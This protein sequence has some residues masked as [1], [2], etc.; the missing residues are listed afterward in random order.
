MKKSARIIS[1]LLLLSLI[2]SIVAVAVSAADLNTEAPIS[3]EEI[4]QE[5]L[6]M[7]V[8]SNNASENGEKIALLTNKEGKACGAPYSADGVVMVPL[9]PIVN[10][11]DTQYTMTG[12]DTYNLIFSGRTVSLTEGEILTSGDIIPLL[13][14]PVVKAEGGLSIMYIALNDV[15][16]IFDGYFVTYDEAGLIYVSR[17]DEFVNRN[18]NEELMQSVAKTFIYTD[19]DFRQIV[20]ENGKSIISYTALG[21][22]QS[23]AYDYK[24]YTASVVDNYKDTAELTELYSMLSEGTNN[25]NHPYINTSQAKFDELNLTYL[26]TEGTEYYDEEL[27]WYIE[28]QIAYADKYLA[29]WANLDENKNYVSLKEGQ[30][31]YDSEGK[32]NEGFS[33]NQNTQGWNTN[34]TTGT[35]HSVAEMPYTETG[36][37]NTPGYGYDPAG[38]RLNVL[39]N[40]ETA[41]VGAL[42]PVALAYQIT[43]DGKYLAFA[44]DWMTALCSWEH[45]GPGHYLNCANTARPLA[46]AYDWLYND[47]VRVYGQEAVEALAE[48]IYE[49]AVYEAMIS[50]SG[51]YTE[52]DRL[53]GEA[54]KYYLHIGNWNPVCTVGMLVASLAVMGEDKGENEDVYRDEALFV[55]AASLG[56]YM[57]RGMSYITLDGG[58]RESAGYWGAVYHMHLISNILS[59]TTGTD[60]G[61]TDYPG[62]DIADYFGCQMEGSDYNRWNYHD[63]GEG[64]QPS[65]WYYMTAK[66]F[67]NPEYAAIRYNQLHSGSTKKAPHRMDLLYYD[68]ELIA[69]MGEVDL[70]LDYSMTSIDATVVRSS[71]GKNALF[72]GV[73]GG[74]NDVAHGQ[75]DSG[76]WMY[77]NMGVRWFVDL[78]SDNYNLAGGGR[79][80]GYYKYS[81]EGNNTLALTSDHTLLPHGQALE[82]GG[83]IVSFKNNSYG[84]ATV[85]DQNSVYAGK[86]EYAR[87]GMLY[88]NSRTTFV[89]QDEVKSNSPETFYWFA[90]YDTSRVFSVDITDDGRVAYMYGVN[91][92][93]E[94]KTLRVSLV[95]DN[96]ALRFE[97]M[98]THT[99]V[100]DTPDA[101]YSP[102]IKGTKENNRDKF[103]KLAVK[104]ENVTEL[105]MAVV[106]E[107]VDDMNNFS[108]GY[109]SLVPMSDWLVEEGEG[110]EGSDKKPVYTVYYA[111]GTSE[112]FYTSRLA[113]GLLDTNNGTNKNPTDTIPTVSR[114][115][116]HGNV[117]VNTA[118]NLVSG[119]YFTIDLNGNILYQSS[120]IRVGKSQST[121]AG[122]TVND[123]KWYNKSY[124]QMRFG[125]TLQT[126]G[127]DCF[128]T[129][130]YFIRDEGADIV[131][132][133]SSV[134][135]KKFVQVTNNATTDEKHRLVI[136]DTD[137]KTSEEFITFNEGQKDGVNYLDVSILGDSS[138]GIEGYMTTDAETGSAVYAPEKL[139]LNDYDS[140]NVT[141][142]FL[143]EK[144]TEFNFADFVLPDNENEEGIS[145][146]YT[147]TCYTDMTF[148]EDT[149]AVNLGPV[150]VKY[151]AGI[152]ESELELYT[153]NIKDAENLEYVLDAVSPKFIVYYK[154]DTH[155]NFYVDNIG[156]A[157]SSSSAYIDNGAR[158]IVLLS[159][160]TLTS[161]ANLGNSQSLTIELSGHTLTVRSGRF[162]MGNADNSY[163]KTCS[164][165]VRGGKLVREGGDVFCVRYGTTLIFED[166]EI[167]TNGRA[168]WDNGAKLIVFDS[169][170]ITATSGYLIYNRYGVINAENGEYDHKVIFKDTTV[171]TV[172]SIL[173]YGEMTNAYANIDI[174]MLGNTKASYKDLFTVASGSSLSEAVHDMHVESTA[175][176]SSA[177]FGMPESNN[178]Y[179]GELTGYKS[180]TLDSNYNI[181]SFV[182]FPLFKVV[183]RDGFYAVEFSSM[184][185]GVKST[186]TLYSDFTVNFYLPVSGNI[187]DLVIV[188]GTPYYINSETGTYTDSGVTYYKLAVPN[189]AADCAA[190]DIVLVFSS[191]GYEEHKTFSVIKYCEI[192]YKD[193]RY[194]DNYALAS[195]VIKY[196]DAAYGYTGA[197]KPESLTSI[198]S[199]AI[200]RENRPEN[201]PNSKS[202]TNVGNAY[203]AIYSAQL[204]L[205]LSL[206]FRFNLNPNFTGTVA[207]NGRSYEVENGM[208]DGE[209]FI[210][211]E[212]RAFDMY[213]PE[214]YITITGLSSDGREILG[215][216]DL[217]AYLQYTDMSDAKLYDLLTSLYTYCTEAYSAKYGIPV[218][219]PVIGDLPFVGTDI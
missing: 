84:S 145:R 200:Y 1:F 127:V 139:I 78:G 206:N 150:M 133:G 189:I 196:I 119:H 88:T 211:F 131:F 117:S 99:F 31:Y 40:G 5:A 172:G 202:T 42:E 50:L 25:F 176:V 160:A 80:K 79:A 38:G 20:G 103:M 90:H 26:S 180:V 182:K 165:T 48:R 96:D 64:A 153:I 60:F 164:V 39:S 195:S 54:T 123:G 146:N 104:A 183:E 212:M 15:E 73:M 129:G 125:A 52:H 45:W 208:C 178:V 41:L 94:V 37:I 147:L 219:R 188:N 141:V 36:D 11:T 4:M 100:L 51:L 205:T 46:T 61:L 218:E 109:T 134:E 77:E 167:E 142:N 162:T 204:D 151:D 214:K 110:S 87:R 116:C 98:D 44:Y 10:Y 209:G 69:N 181:K 23:S 173:E 74:G 113:D 2:I 169:C 161:N 30:W 198:M 197:V 217:R 177:N 132:N 190:E 91:A 67:D 118:V 6:A 112:E 203:I 35:N 155:K 76:N 130:A 108:S 85:I 186:L 115:D 95:S 126:N 27:K 135:A 3:A 32:T 43:R 192:L 49:N 154:G 175:L 149:G 71:W 138:V 82:A 128:S 168:V 58:Y 21:K 207:F 194:S 92:D 140:T 83:E 122:I 86:T 157:F 136:N 62:I 9:L 159:D 199:T 19:I 59:L 16:S 166:V 101:N 57:E 81:A 89:I 111:D 137:I 121:K 144:G 7:K 53:T 216:Y 29:E 13:A 114:I 65:H 97:I 210:L 187:I 68:R 56:H 174:Y 55:I 124:I 185:T 201:M 120:V 18:N 63:D 105:N 14:A 34:L 107:V 170:K 152:T 156:A 47:F 215:T 213:D 106:I 17:Y 163:K 179:H 158:E 33:N 148:D 102:S 75:Y 193:E 22:K 143:V 28:T 191:N 70:K 184:V 72:A 8:G 12:E 66:M 93:G 171:N 24:T